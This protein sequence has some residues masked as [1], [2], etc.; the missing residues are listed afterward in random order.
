M[1][2]EEVE[3]SSGSDS[4]GSLCEDEVIEGGH[5]EVILVPRVRTVPPVSIRIVTLARAYAC[6]HQH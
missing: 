6:V 4:D 2:I 5:K 3:D 1:E